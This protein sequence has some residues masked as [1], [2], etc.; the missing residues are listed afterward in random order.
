MTGDN[1]SMNHAEASPDQV[2][3]TVFWVIAL[4]TLA[5]I[6]GVLVLIR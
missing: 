2:A 6:A 5:F 1:L 3:K 4:S